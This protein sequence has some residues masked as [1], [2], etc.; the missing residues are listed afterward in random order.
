M[1]PFGLSAQ[2]HGQSWS[3]APFQLAEGGVDLEL[4]RKPVTEGL[5]RVLNLPQ[6]QHREKLS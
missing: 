2:A 3:W 4:Q 5:T 6:K 1:M